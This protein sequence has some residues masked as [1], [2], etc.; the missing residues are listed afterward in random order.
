MVLLKIKLLKII[1]LFLV[2]H[3]KLNQNT[4]VSFW[5]AMRT[6]VLLKILKKN[7]KVP[8]SKIV[9]IIRE[10]NLKNWKRKGY[11]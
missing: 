1:F 8:K 9:I 10:G 5:K 3:Y 7:N 11:A 2:A 6:K 4:F